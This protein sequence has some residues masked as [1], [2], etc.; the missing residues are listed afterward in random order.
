MAKETLL[1]LLF[2]MKI[3][4]GTALL[5]SVAYGLGLRIKISRLWLGRILWGWVAVT[6]ITFLCFV[7]V[8]Y[9]NGMIK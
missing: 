1:A 3:E 5:F 9:T 8:A 4:F 2:A 7:Y 6:G